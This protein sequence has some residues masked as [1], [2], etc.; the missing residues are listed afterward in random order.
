MEVKE[1]TSEGKPPSLR[2]RIA[3]FFIAPALGWIIVVATGMRLEWSVNVR[4][5]REGHEDDEMKDYK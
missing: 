3:H 1:R 4:L 5:W 2:I